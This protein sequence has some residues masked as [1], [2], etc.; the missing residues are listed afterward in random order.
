[1]DEKEASFVYKKRSFRTYFNNY[2][3]FGIQ[4]AYIE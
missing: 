1:M 4:L 2:E 3:F